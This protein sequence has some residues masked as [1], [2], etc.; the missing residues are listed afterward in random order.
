MSQ[1]IV[2]VMG[3]GGW[4][5]AL[6]RLLAENGH[7]VSLWARRPELAAQIAETRRNEDY[8]PGIEIPKGV[9]VTAD[10]AAAVAKAEICILA[11]PSHGVRSVL[12][13]AASHVPEKAILV[14]AVKGIENGTLSRM[15]EVIEQSFIARGAPRIAVLSG[16]SFALEVASGHPTA[17]VVASTSH[18]DAKVVQAA[19]SNDHFR[20]YT[21]GDV[22][23]VEIGGAMKNVIAIAA[24]VVDGLRL[25]HSTKASLITR[26]LAE[27][28]RLAQALGGSERTAA[29]LSGLGDLVLTSTGHLSRN[30]AVGQKLG[31]GRELSEA[32]AMKMVAEGVKT[33]KS[34]YEL[35]QK[36]G[37]EMP[38]VTEVWKVLYQQKAPR[39][40]IRDLMSRALKEE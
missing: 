23:G 28:G 19:C 5:T 26:G 22:R 9:T 33:A 25:G 14:S 34:G 16:P 2:A 7:K 35:A 12:M 29:G 38:I 40:G 10:A 13:A 24:G 4:G 32:I 8:L 15:S 17:V 18:R 39:D 27:I 3:A 1:K 31:E 6:A 21:G 36:H 11:M 30:R 20:C 37:V